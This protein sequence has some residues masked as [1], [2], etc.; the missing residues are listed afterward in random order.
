MSTESDGQSAW[1]PIR[2]VRI[3]PDDG[4]VVSIRDLGN[5]IEVEMHP[6]HIR[7][8][9]ADDLTETIAENLLAN[10]WGK[11]SGEPP[12]DG[13]ILPTIRFVREA[14]DSERTALIVDTVRHIRV[15]MEPDGVTEGAV[16]ELTDKV[17]T[18]M[19]EAGWRRRA[20]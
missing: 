8:T 20:A 5:R 15:L 6:H 4:S 12:D 14:V 16:N 10:H 18:H 13:W 1:L 9:V 17:T 3:V 7:Q 19:R 11:F 2:I